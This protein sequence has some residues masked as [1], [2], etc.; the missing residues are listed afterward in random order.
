MSLA[1]AA[2]PKMYYSENLRRCDD[3]IIETIELCDTHDPE[4]IISCLKGMM[5][6]GDSCELMKNPPMPVL[7]IM[8]DHDNFMPMAK[9]EAM[10]E[11]FPKVRFEIVEN[12]GHNS[13]IEE[14][15]KVVQIVKSFI[16]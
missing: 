12:T 11:E 8:G 5:Q 6:R 1:E 3:K 14:P 13:F 4:G 7:A 9:I 2:V 10:K 16:R 15:D